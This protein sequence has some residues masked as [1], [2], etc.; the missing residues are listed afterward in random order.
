MWPVKY[1]IITCLISIK[2]PLVSISHKG[3]RIAKISILKLERIIEKFLTIA[4]SMS[5]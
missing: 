2:Y 5:R 4:A 3:V 1:D